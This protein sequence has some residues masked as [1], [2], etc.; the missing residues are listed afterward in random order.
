MTDYLSTVLLDT[1]ESWGSLFQDISV[2]KPM[3]EAIL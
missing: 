2:F 1:I 3:I